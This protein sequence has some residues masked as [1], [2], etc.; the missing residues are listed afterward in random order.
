DL[1]CIIPPNLV[2]EDLKVE[3][4]RADSE[5]LVHLEQHKDYHRRAN[6]SKKKIKDGDFSLHLKKLRAGDEGVYR[7]VVYKEQNCVFS[8]DTVLELG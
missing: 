7:C 1:P 3:W 5:T 4:R 8:A 2:N 6:F